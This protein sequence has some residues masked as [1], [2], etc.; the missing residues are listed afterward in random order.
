MVT[1]N[2]ALNN[3]HKKDVVKCFVCYDCNNL[4]LSAQGTNRVM[5]SFTQHNLAGENIIP[6][7]VLYRGTLFRHG[8]NSPF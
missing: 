6:E 8:L 7:L 2:D 5:L 1:G 4:L 3:V